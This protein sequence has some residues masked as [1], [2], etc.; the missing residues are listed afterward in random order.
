MRYFKVISLLGII[1]FL[2]HCKKEVPTKLP[3]KLNPPV[4][5]SYYK[6]IG[7]YTGNYINIVDSTDTLFVYTAF[8]IINGDTDIPQ[9]NGGTIYSIY[10]KHI[11]E[12]DTYWVCNTYLAKPYRYMKCGDNLNS[13]NLETQQGQ[14][15]TYSYQC[16]PNTG[17]PVTYYI[18]ST[19][20]PYTSKVYFRYFNCQGTLIQ[21][22]YNYK[23]I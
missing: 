15:E 22:T 11:G 20:H 19:Q 8:I 10:T 5:N 3:I 6:H 7:K 13:L 18:D 1:I 14:L 2:L 17:M 21:T 23:K 4:D 12:I 9:G 16:Q